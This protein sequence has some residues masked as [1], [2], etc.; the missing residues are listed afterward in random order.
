MTRVGA[1]I[2]VLALPFF[3][4]CVDR[5]FVVK[6]NVPAAQVFID[7]QPLGPAPVDAKWE[8]AGEY[9][10]T[11]LAPGYE[12]LTEKVRFKPKWYM[13]PPLDLFVEVFYPGRIEDVRR[14]DLT[15]VPARPLTDAELLNAANNLRSQGQALP[16]SRVPDEKA[17]PT[18]PIN[19]TPTIPVAPIPEAPAGPPPSLAL[20]NNVPLMR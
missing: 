6:T 3:V 10:F 9:T 19:F 18:T 16:P 2:L 1:M 15:L 5:R 20:P 11:A 8:F 14:V 17:P 13:Y 7:G 4:G 12:P